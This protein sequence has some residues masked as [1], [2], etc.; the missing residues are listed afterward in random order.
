MSNTLNQILVD[1]TWSPMESSQKIKSEHSLAHLSYWKSNQRWN[2][3]GKQYFEILWE[4]KGWKV[5]RWDPLDPL[6]TQR[7]R[8]NLRKSSRA[9][10]QNKHIACVITKLKQAYHSFFKSQVE[11]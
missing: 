2:W 4:E 3:K 11:N 5:V 6:E 1:K 8:W 7:F 10:S 9:V